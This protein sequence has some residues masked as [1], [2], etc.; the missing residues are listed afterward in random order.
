[1]NEQEIIIGIIMV[2]CVTWIV[3]RTILC[4]KRITR[5]ENPCEG[6]PCGCNTSAKSCPNEK[7]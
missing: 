7:K 5:K 3:R 6:C 1:M 2:V 4:L